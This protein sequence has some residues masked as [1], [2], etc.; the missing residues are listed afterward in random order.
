[1]KPKALVLIALLLSSQPVPL[2][3]LTDHD[4]C[5]QSCMRRFGEFEAHHFL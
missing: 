4:K 1:M 5:R 2:P 3:R